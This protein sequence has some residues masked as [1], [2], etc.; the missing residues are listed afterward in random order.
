MNVKNIILKL[1][2][3]K[4]VQKLLGVSK[5]AVSN[6]IKRDSFPDYALPI[7]SQQL[8][9]KNQNKNFINT[10]LLI[11]CG[12]IS[13]YKTPEI[14]RQLKENKHRVIPILTEGGRQFI[15]PLTISAIS[16]E[17]CF[18]NLFDL[19]SE[20]EMGH[21]KLARLADLIL[22]VPASANF[23]ANLA[24]GFSK[25]LASTVCLASKTPT[26]LCPAMN[27]T[28]WENDATQQNISILKKRGFSIINPDFGLSACGETGVG[29]LANMDVIVS[30]TLQISEEL[31]TM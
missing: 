13:A 21:I 14:I 12:G 7:I 23:I 25:D 18:L 6:Y 1:G 29:R 8:K 5:S 15:T 20:S 2:G 26:I 9:K 16:E 30:E 10:V 19:T 24:Y 11:I 27:P 17:K 4:G 22:I 28:M 31:N 3:S